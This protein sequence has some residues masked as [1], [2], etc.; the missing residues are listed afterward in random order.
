M[1][2]E[3][4]KEYELAVLADDESSEME[5]GKV[6]EGTEVTSKLPSKAIH[7]A[8]PIK[9]RNLATLFV[10]KFNA[11]PEIISR[12]REAL[13]FHP[14]ILR[15]LLITPPIQTAN[16]TNKVRKETPTAPNVVSASGV[17]PANPEIN[18]NEFLAKTLEEMEEP[19][20]Q[21]Q[22]QLIDNN[23]S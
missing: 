20:S 13:R 3:V 4:L 22:D 17:K 14:N 5:V 16:K 10:Y 7:L 1:D 11:A 23:E 18:S 12:M 15:S 2:K 6:L 9:K 21:D 19:G 8:Y